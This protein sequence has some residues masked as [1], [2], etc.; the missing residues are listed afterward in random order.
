MAP[1]SLRKNEYSFKSDIWA[2]GIIFYEMLF[3]DT[4]WRA[5]NEKELLRKIE[6]ESIQT[7]ISNKN[8]SAQSKE[9]LVKTLKVDK[10]SRMGPDELKEFN[11]RGSSG[12]VLG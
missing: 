2:L 1:E 7:I 9:F 3:H 4:P 8:I 11:F 6:S 5:K 12:N 10:S